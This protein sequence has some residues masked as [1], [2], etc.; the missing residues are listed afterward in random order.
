MMM[1]MSM[2]GIM[3]VVSMMMIMSM[4]AIMMVVCMT[5][6]VSMDA[7]MTT[8]HLL[9][10]IAALFLGRRGGIGSALAVPAQSGPGVLRHSGFRAVQLRGVCLGLP[11]KR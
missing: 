9:P 4:D 1:N 3:M 6:I 11:K 5:M 7:I 2:D 10:P 8:H